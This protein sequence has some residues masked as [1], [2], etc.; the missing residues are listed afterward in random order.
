MDV[1]SA[2]G[3]DG[4]FAWYENDGHGSFESHQIT[5][6]AMSARAVFA[7]DMDGDGDIDALCG[8]PGD[9]TVAWYE[10]HRID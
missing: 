2:S 10:S 3:F 1:P 4:T 8:G 5:D 9:T 7:V 6:T